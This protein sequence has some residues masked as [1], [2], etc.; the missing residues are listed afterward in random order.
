MGS[1]VTYRSIRLAAKSINVVHHVY[2]VFIAES[3]E[4]KLDSV[5]HSP[6]PSFEKN[7]KLIL[8]VL[9]EQEVFIAKKS[10]HHNG[11][12]KLRPLFDQLKYDDLLK[13]I[14]H[15]TNALLD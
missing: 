11:F 15:T 14:K 6:P 1:N 4:Q 10:R 3:S 5:H 2:N 12:K 9:Q 13:W 7:F 8:S